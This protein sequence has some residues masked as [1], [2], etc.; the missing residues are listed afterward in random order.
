MINPKSIDLAALPS[1]ALCDCPKGT[2]KGNRTTLPP[3][4]AIYFALDSLGNMQYVGR[5]VNLQQR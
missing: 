5:S 2:A 1:V 3:V 4:P